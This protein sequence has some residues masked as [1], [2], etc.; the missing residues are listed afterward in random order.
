MIKK[1]RVF[2][3]WESEV[4]AEHE[5]EAIALA[6]DELHLSNDS[7]DNHIKVEEEGKQEFFAITSVARADLEG[8]GFDTSGVGDD[9]MKHLASKMADAFLEGDYWIALE[10]IAENLEIPK[11]KENENTKAN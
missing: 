10:T 1:Y 5:D 8:Q 6:L 7:L 11:K 2:L 3:N 9:T 4:N